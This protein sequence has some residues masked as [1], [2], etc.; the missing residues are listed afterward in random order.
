MSTAGNQKQ[1]SFL[2]SPAFKELSRRSFEAHAATPQVSPEAYF[3]SRHSQLRDEITARKLIYLDTNHWI[4]LRHVVLN[5]PREGRGYRELHGLLTTLFAQGKICCPV[6]FFV[7]IE[8]TKQTD[9]VTRLATAR[10]M[11]E[12]SSG[13]CFQFPPDL[14]RSE[15][16][17]FLLKAVARQPLGDKAWAFTKVGF[18][19]GQIIPELPLVP[20]ATNTLLQ[21]AW[22]DT[23]WAVRLEH[24]LD[25][26]A[27]PREVMDFW[28]KYAAAAN[29]DATFYRSSN[30]SYPRVLEREKALFLRKL[31]KEE[32][33]P[34]GQELWATYPELRD[35]ARLRLMPPAVASPQAL[36]SLQILAGITAAAMRTNM[37]FEANDILDFR[38]AALAIPY[39]DAVCCDN[40]MA[41]RLRSKPCEFGKL[42]G[43]QI[44]SRPQEVVCFLKVQPRS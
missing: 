8:L 31:L 24:M 22:I 18:L 19:V 29:A 27:P 11:D 40:P 39:C 21:K 35:V 41:A 5:S 36:P 20:G 34:I 28:E 38:H 37:K 16:K 30:L 26:P 25:M 23:V 17:H 6:S 12:L 13:L 1:A 42:Y 4:N 7:F 43:T 10:L 2:L 44:L 33:E 3:R 15:L 9:P 14:A 32:L